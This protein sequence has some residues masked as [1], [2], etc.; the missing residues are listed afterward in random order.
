MINCRQIILVAS[1]PSHC[2]CTHSHK[3][4]SSNIIIGLTDAGKIFPK[5]YFRCNRYAQ[6]LLTPPG[7]EI[8]DT[9]SLPGECLFL[10]Y[11]L[12]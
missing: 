2:G 4:A 6:G 5:I 10:S 8:K 3:K 1:K 12:T 7:P 9:H 11:L